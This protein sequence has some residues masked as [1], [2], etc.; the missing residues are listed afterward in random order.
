ML[1]RCPE[2]KRKGK[3]TGGAGGGKEEEK[4][5]GVKVK[6]GKTQKK[7]RLNFETGGSKERGGDKG[8]VGV[9]VWLPRRRMGG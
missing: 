2:K 1:W 6:G 8:R 5:G 7:F 4:E 9:E 3:K